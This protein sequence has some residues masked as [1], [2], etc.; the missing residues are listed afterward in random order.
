MSAHNPGQLT[1]LKDV[2]A[3]ELEFMKSGNANV[4]LFSNDEEQ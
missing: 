2:I 3:I 4:L 1:S